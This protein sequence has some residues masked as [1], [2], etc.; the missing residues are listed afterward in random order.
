MKTDF[1]KSAKL[2]RAAHAGGFTLLELL[3]VLGVIAVL[4]AV[5]L[6]A[7]AGAK[8]QSKIAMCAS[9]VRQLALVCQIYANE[10]GDRLPGLSGSSYW[11][12][13]LPASTANALLNWGAQTNTFYCPGT[14]PKF[15][16]YEN[17]SGPGSTLWNYGAGA[18]YHIVGY[19]LAFYG[20]ASRLN[21]TNQNTTIQPEAIHD[22]PSTGTS[23]TYRASERVLVADAILSAGNALPGY[24]HPE[25][26]Y[27]DIAGGFY[28]HHV[29]PHLKGALPM[30]G[31]L[32][33][34]DGHVDWR[35][36]QMMVPRTD[37]NM[38]YFWW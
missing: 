1:I 16:D 11:P 5:Q 21:P 18:G 2:P 28:M 20:Q 7:L 26:N 37:N 19:S 10:S 9:H 27:T 38:P 12:W 36:F 35:S 17:W 31:N 4:I 30:G 25:N 33:F 3:V 6:P 23:T 8:S 15:T 29:S 34:K 32:G 13:D 22:F 24:T 14:A